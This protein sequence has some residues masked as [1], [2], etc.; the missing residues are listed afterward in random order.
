MPRHCARCPFDLGRRRCP[1]PGRR[2]CCAR[3]L[4]CRRV[5]GGGR[6]AADR[7][8]RRRQGGR[9]DGGRPGKRRRRTSSARWSAWSTCRRRACGR[10]GR[11]RLHAGPAGRQQSSD[12][13]G[14]RRQPEIVELLRQEPGRRTWR[15]A[16]SPAAARRCCPRRSRA[17]RWRT[18]SASRGCCTPAGRPSTR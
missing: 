15:C 17:S 3:R 9:S 1:R 5:R 12:R 6:G 16:C 7:R 8:G 11:I 14:R 13:G 2:S 18:S 10:C 4:R